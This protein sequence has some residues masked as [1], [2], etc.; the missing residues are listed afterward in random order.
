MKKILVVLM[1]ILLTSSLFAAEATK[2]EKKLA[3]D[4]RVMLDAIVDMQKAAFYDDARIIKKAT[5]NLITSLD[6]LLAVEPST[7]LPKDQKHAGAFAKKREKMI[8]MYA[9]DLLVSLDAGQFD[10]VI[11]NYNQIIRQCDSC[12]LRIRARK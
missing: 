6:S 9:E 10:D 11:E 12:H 7:Y 8:R 2:A 1:T 4:M 5:N 3:S